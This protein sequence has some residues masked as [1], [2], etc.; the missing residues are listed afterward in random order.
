MG[1]YTGFL[2][3]LDLIRNICACNQFSFM[4]KLVH[5]KKKYIPKRLESSQA[6]FFVFIIQPTISPALYMRGNKSQLPC[7]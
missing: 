1:S 4:I 6:T 7:V 3:D 2:V 5:V